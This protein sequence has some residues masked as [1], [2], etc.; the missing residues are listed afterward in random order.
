MPRHTDSGIDTICRHADR[1][2]AKIPEEYDGLDGM[3][4]MAHQHGDCVTR[5]CTLQSSRESLI[6]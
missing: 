1:E 2:G 5:S 4:M 3:L 6:C